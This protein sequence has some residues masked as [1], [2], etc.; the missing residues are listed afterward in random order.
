MDNEKSSRFTRLKGFLLAELLRLL[1]RSWRI[2]IINKEVLDNL[3]EENTPFLLF[4][5]HGNYAPVFPI[6]EGYKAAVISSR[7]ER[8]SVIAEVCLNFGYQS[9]LLSDRPSREAF[10]QMRRILSDS[11]AAGTAADGPLGPRHQVK[12]GLIYL[13]AH[14]NLRLLPLA[15][16]CSSKIVLKKRWDKLEIPLPCARIALVFGEAFE[17]PSGGGKERIR[18]TAA[19][20][21]E[22]LQLLEA[23]AEEIVSS[24]YR[25]N[26]KPAG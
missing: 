22:T 4:F 9:A 3:Y 26:R 2:S 18:Q 19:H 24:G 20:T 7:S 17:I 23:Q 15:V 8:G 11:R 12:A 1:R 10:D 6:L 14:L 5:W 13:A 21:R 16:A 25:R